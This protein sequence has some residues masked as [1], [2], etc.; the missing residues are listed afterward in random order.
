MSHPTP[1][2]RDKKPF[3]YLDEKLLMTM[4]CAAETTQIL[5]QTNI[6]FYNLHKTCG[7][8]L[9]LGSFSHQPP[10][11]DQ[12]AP[13]A[14]STSTKKTNS[15]RSRI[16]V[17]GKKVRHAVQSWKRKVIQRQCFKRIF[18]RR[19]LLSLPPFSS[20]QRK[21]KSLSSQGVSRI[22]EC[23][24]T[25]RSSVLCNPP[26]AID[27]QVLNRGPRNPCQWWWFAHTNL[28]LY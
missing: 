9:K 7:T 27:Q 4:P 8:V 22:Y 23:R 14:R 15:D 11:I 28:H 25:P 20:L 17:Q 6:F 10:C 26:G 12:S 3:C 18:P 13:L 5:H 1:G 16:F 2:L 19:L 21:E 24:F